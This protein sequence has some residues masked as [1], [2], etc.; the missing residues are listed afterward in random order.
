MVLYELLGFSPEGH[1][2]RD[3]DSGFFELND[4]LP[5][6]PG[7]GSTAGAASKGPP[8]LVYHRPSASHL[9]WQRWQFWAKKPAIPN[10]IQLSHNPW[11]KQEQS[12]FSAIVWP[13]RAIML[14][15]SR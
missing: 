7:Q 3:V 13:R 9:R 8:D 1:A 10:Q 15:F 14:R 11:E 4:V 12:P 6:N 2:K 5:A